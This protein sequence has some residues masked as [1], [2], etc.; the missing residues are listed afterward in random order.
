LY[1]QH[2]YIPFSKKSRIHV[3]APFNFFFNLS[4]IVE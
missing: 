4:E 1:T 3:G 2:L